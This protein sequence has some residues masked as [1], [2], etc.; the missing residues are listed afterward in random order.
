[1]VSPLLATKLYVP[2]RRDVVP[3]PRLRERLDRGAAAALTLVSAPAGF[4]KTT[5][6]AEWLAATPDRTWAA[7]WLSLD[8]HDNQPASFWTYLIA[9]LQNAVPGIGAGALTL[10]QASQPP[11]LDTVLITL[12]NELSAVTHDV[13]LVLDDYHAIDARDVQEGMAFLLEHLPQRIH[14]MIASRADPALPLARL[15]ARGELVEIRIADLRFTPDEAAAFLTA[16]MGLD[17]TAADVAAL[18]TRTEGWIAALQ[19]A[20]LSLRGRDDAAGFIAGFAGD[21]RYIVDYLVEEVLRRQPDPVRAF[22]LHTAILDRLSGPLCDVVTGQAGGQATLEALERANLFLVPLDG[23]RRW[24]RYHHLFADVLRAHLLDE[25]PDHVPDLHRRASDWYEQHD[26]PDEAI[27]HALAAGDFA[28]AADL[29]ERV[30]LVM[31]QGR[32]Q[33]TVLGWLRALPDE[34]LRYRPVLS[35]WYAHALLAGGVLAGVED[36]LRD[37]ERWLNTSATGREGAQPSAAM[38]VVDEAELHRLPGRVAVARAGQA[39]ARGDLAA[40]VQHAQQVLALAPE[41]DQLSRGGAAGFLGLAAWASG[42]LETAHRTFAAG[43]AQLQRAGNITDVVGGT[44]ALAD[45]RSAQGRLRAARRTYEGALQLA[46]EQGT[47]ALRGTADMHVGLAELYCE[48]GDLDAAVRRLRQAEEQGE[49]TGFPQHPYRRRVAAARL[50]AAQGDLGGA[51]AL[52][53][54]AERRYVGDFYPEVRP[55][56]ALK[57]RIWL[58]QGRLADAVTWAHERDLSP[59]DDLSYLRE[60]EHLTLARVL[61]ARYTSDR[62]DRSLRDARRLLA[63]L[64]HAAEVGERAGS[65]LAILVL[66]ALVHQAQGDLPAAL[67]PLA[68]AL[69][70]AEPEGYVRIFVDEGSPMTTLLEAAAKHGAARSYVRRLLAAG[71]VAADSPPTSQNLIEPLSDRELAVLRL[72][73]TDLDG[74][75]IA[76]EL[77]VSLN[78]MRTHTKNIYGKLGV[79][80][81]RAAVRRAEELQLLSRTRNH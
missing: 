45:I 11:P 61:L 50:R 16:V 55:I 57:A 35:V 2:R 46:A 65:V 19:L 5:L 31:F 67:A 27:R 81:R 64:L 8:P 60:L 13:V 62:A 78:T 79:N 51:L 30:G 76:R 49:H 54:E 17:L 22:L 69:A 21:D 68:R 39:L 56:A 75:A 59:D 36:R 20:A 12:V 66:Q 74:P 3:R 77:L 15:R 24:Y 71:G 58:A 7:A 52:L 33:A 18:E 48:W 72:L 80:N 28:R 37:A 41:D 23:R 44:L 32:Q 43:L 29:V 14:L 40:T 9:A 1:M 53:D 42:D 63:R 6:L 38:V 4:G 10:L 25:Q 34:L 73:G 47:P 70:L 26:L